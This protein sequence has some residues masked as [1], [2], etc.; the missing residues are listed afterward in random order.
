[1]FVYNFIAIVIC[2]S[3]QDYETE[4]KNRGLCVIAFVYVCVCLQRYSVQQ[5][6]LLDPSHSV[7]NIL[8][9]LLGYREETTALSDPIKLHCQDMPI[10]IKSVCVV[11]SQPVKELDKYKF[12]SVSR[13]L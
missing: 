6:S 4:E 12:S 11:T 10:I 9:V 1:M 8:L 13:D 2:A 7:R 5:H 3:T